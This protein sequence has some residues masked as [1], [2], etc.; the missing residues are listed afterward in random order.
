MRQFEQKHKPRELKGIVM[1]VLTRKRSEMIQI[2]DDIRIK[3]IRTATGHVKLG[4]EAPDHVRV[5]RAELVGTP[6]VVKTVHRLQPG[7]FKARGT[8]SCLSDQ[9]PHPHIA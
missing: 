8:T 5:L 3:V 4:I 7:D 2:G 1:L 9:Y 6:P